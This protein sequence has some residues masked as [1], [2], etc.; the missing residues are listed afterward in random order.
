MLAEGADDFYASWRKAAETVRT[1][2]WISSHVL[3]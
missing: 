3:G 2:Y 1:H